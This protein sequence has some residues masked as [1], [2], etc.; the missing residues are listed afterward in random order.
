M[1][2]RYVAFDSDG[3]KVKGVVDAENET[4][5]IYHLRNQD[6]SP[7]SVAPY[8]EK[9]ASMW[10]IE[11]ME[12]DVHKLKIKKK[13]LMQFADKMS[14]MLRAGV[15]LAMA[16]DVIVNSEKNRRYKK[17]YRAILTDLYGGASLAD[18]MRSFKAFPTVV[19]NMVA[20]GEKTGKLD[21]AFGRISELYEKEL[22]LNGKITSAFTYPAF[23]VA[24]MIVLF[25]AM[26][27]FVL[28]RF[29]GMYDQFGGELPAITQF[30]VNMSDF[31][32]HYGWIILVV[33]G[34]IAGAFV[35]LLK[36]NPAFSN[37][38]AQLFL[39]VPIIGRLSMVS[40]TCN[41]SRISAA[42]LLAGVEV[43]ESVRIAATVIKNKYIC[44]AVESALESVAQGS[45]LN[46]ALQKLNIFEQLFISMI[47]IGEEASMLPDTF[48]KMA[49]L[50]EAESSDATKKMTS[51]LE[52]ALTVGIGLVIALMVI[53]II[54]P[55]FNMYT[56]ILG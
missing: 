6:L 55:M 39:K 24:L 7:V 25:I 52:P 1:K 41:F 21:W 12:P 20:S 43:V 36:V 5:A 27:T 51:I 26:T 3:K 56:V 31:M 8:K 4:G 30:M 33:V 40:N 34:V 23:L 54:L 46:T 22:A 9:A 37:M 38:M 49:D 47:M 28:P 17:I 10:E 2:Y 18:S 50:Y 45:K 14:I 16:M 32:I 13:D 48:Q 42:L 35:L 53:A 44:T 19:V 15:T 29:S 11:I